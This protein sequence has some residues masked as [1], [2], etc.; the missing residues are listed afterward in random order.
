[1][2]VCV[3]SGT[4]FP[5][6][7]NW[8]PPFFAE[9]FVSHGSLFSPSSRTMKQIKK[10]SAN[11]MAGPPSDVWMLPTGLISPQVKRKPQR[12]VMKTLVLPGGGRKKKKKSKEFM[13]MVSFTPEL[14]SVPASIGGGA[15]NNF[16]VPPHPRSFSMLTSTKWDLF[17]ICPD[18]CSCFLQD[19]QKTWKNS[20]N[21]LFPLHA[22]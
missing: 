14:C 21:P 17:L 7:E 15:N 12:F 6:S 5:P 13:P 8:S 4:A 3:C 10:A 11:S 20:R 2:C 1:M 9:I 18:E 22:L 16:N 19:I